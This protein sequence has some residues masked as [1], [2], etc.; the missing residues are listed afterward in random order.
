MSQFEQLTAL[1][2]L[3]EKHAYYREQYNAHEMSSFKQNKM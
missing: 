1:L 2:Q 3:L